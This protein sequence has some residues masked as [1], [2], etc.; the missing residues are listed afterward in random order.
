METHRHLDS[1]IQVNGS[2]HDVPGWDGTVSL[3]I[4]L[5]A[6]SGGHCEKQRPPHVAADFICF[7]QIKQTKQCL[8]KL[9]KNC[10]Q[11]ACKEKQN[12]LE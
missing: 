3:V 4:G 2:V 6:P 8:Q 10:K 7:K 12:N 5:L 9:Q 1:R 11:T